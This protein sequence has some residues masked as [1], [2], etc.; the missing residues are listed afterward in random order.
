MQPSTRAP[1]LGYHERNQL[2]QASDCSLLR[3]QK[4]SATDLV[5]LPSLAPRLSPQSHPVLLAHA[6][7]LFGMQPMTRPV[8]CH[9]IYLFMSFLV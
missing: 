1:E 3:A 7:C 4:I 2:K 8:F 5:M 6:H 9:A